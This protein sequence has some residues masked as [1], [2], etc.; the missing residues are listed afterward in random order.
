MSEEPDQLKILYNLIWLKNSIK[1][2]VKML[3]VKDVENKVYGVAQIGENFLWNIKKAVCPMIALCVQKVLEP[4]ENTNS[5]WTLIED[6]VTNVK[7][8]G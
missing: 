1:L 3:N 2:I 7:I 8:V 5:T 6:L 4:R